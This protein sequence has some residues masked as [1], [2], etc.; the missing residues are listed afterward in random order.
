[1]SGIYTTAKAAV[2]QVS[3]T[4]RVEMEPLGVRV[5]TAIIGTVE[6]NFFNNGL[7]EPFHLPANSY[8]TPIRKRLEDQRGGANVPSRQNVNVT[9]R[10]IIN[11]VVGGAKGCIW[12]GGRSTE[13][14]WLTW[15]LPTWAL[16]WMVNGSRGLEELKEYYSNK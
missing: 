16:E 5:V 2:K 9:A 4:M 10:N 14:R 1:M 7:K 11:D 3:E 13:A 8:Y 15:L 12:R 6:T